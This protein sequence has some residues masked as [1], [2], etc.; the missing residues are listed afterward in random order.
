MMRHR[1]SLGC[2]S[3][4]I[5]NTTQ[6]SKTQVTG[7]LKDL[8]ALKIAKYATVSNNGSSRGRGYKLWQPTERF[9]EYWD[10]AGLSDYQYKIDPDYL[11]RVKKNPVDK[12]KIATYNTTSQKKPKLRI[13]N[14]SKK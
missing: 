12:K 9:K 4:E 14:K 2:S 8:Q 1:H 6:V 10:R 11:Q 3:E 13:K 5:A 7:L